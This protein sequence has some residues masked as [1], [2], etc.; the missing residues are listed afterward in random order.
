[1]IL[2]FIDKKMRIILCV[3]LCVVVVVGN[4]EIVKE[5]NSLVFP[6]IDNNI[7]YSQNRV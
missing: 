3:A 7:V 6:Q 5:K 1:M 2:I 4:I